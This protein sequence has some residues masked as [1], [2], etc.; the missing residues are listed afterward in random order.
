MRTLHVIMG[1]TMHEKEK[2]H[3]PPNAGN[4]IQSFLGM[5]KVINSPIYSIQR[6]VFKE[7]ESLKSKSSVCIVFS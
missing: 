7:F 4:G 5:F 2:K 1:F 6:E 3:V